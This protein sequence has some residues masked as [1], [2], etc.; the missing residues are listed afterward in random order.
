MGKVLWDL[1]FD[2]SMYRSKFLDRRLVTRDQVQIVSSLVSR[3][4]I[5]AH[6]DR[7]WSRGEG[8]LYIATHTEDNERSSWDLIIH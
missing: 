2:V 6:A 5:Y 8:T 1:I 4:R 7:A 3:N